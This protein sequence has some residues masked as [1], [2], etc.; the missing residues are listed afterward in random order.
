MTT[1]SIAPE[2]KQF[3]AATWDEHTAYATNLAALASQALCVQMAALAANVSLSGRRIVVFNPLPWPRT[4]LAQ[5]AGQW[6]A[7]TRVLAPAGGELPTS[8]VGGR[9]EFVAK[10]VPAFGYR[11]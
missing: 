3:M 9:L 8:V 2:A 10:D 6:V 11:T 7:G 5:V 1:A 4:D